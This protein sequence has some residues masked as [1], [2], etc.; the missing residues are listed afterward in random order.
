MDP[1]DNVDRGWFGTVCVLA[2]VLFLLVVW[3]YAA[4]F[5]LWIFS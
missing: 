2:A 3:G 5:I 4:K 1:E